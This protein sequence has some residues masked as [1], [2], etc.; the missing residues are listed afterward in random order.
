ML[1]P[2]DES[3]LRS[4]CNRKLETLEH[5]SRRLITDTF[6]ESYGKEYW[7]ATLPGG[8]PLVKAEIKSGVNSRM[9]SDPGRYPRWIDAV[10]LDDV[11]YFL[12]RDDLYKAYFKEVF[13]PFYSGRNELESVFGRLVDV[14][15]KLS[16]GNAISDHEAERVLCYS[17]DIIGCY[18]SHYSTLGKARKYNVPFFTRAQ[19]SLGNE[20]VRERP[21]H[22]WEI[23]RLPYSDRWEKIELRSGESYKIWV[24]VDGAFPEDSYSVEW[25]VKCGNR[26]EQ[27]SGNVAEVVLTDSDVSLFL[28]I[29]FTLKTTNSWHK[30]AV[31]FNRSL[32]YDDRIEWSAADAILPPIE[33]TY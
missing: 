29:H 9:A 5:W 12:C 16:H 18:K 7:D 6:A 21:E 24:E 23:M 8:Q 11:R 10:L 31:E 27:G 17:D 32:D 30:H 25:L 19:D 3:G 2:S 1:M 13:E 22:T 15:N 26:R 33:S 14:R 4:F 28:Q 20:F